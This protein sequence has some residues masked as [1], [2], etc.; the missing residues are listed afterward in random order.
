MPFFSLPRSSFGNVRSGNAATFVTPL[1]RATVDFVTEYSAFGGA[2]GAGRPSIAAR[3]A[4]S[5]SSAMSS[6]APSGDGVTV[7]V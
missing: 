7:S 5:I 3:P 1:S 6:S 4:F 2:T